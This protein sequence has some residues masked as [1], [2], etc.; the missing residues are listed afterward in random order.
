MNGINRAQRN[1]LTRLLALSLALWLTRYI[2]VIYLRIFLL[3]KI[4]LQSVH[5]DWLALG[6]WLLEQRLMTES[7]SLISTIQLFTDPSKVIS[8]FEKLLLMLLL[9]LLNWSMVREE[10]VGLLSDLRS[11][12]FEK[13]GHD[14]LSPRFEE[15]LEVFYHCL[16]TRLT[17]N[18]DSKDIFLNL[19]YRCLSN[20][21]CVI[22]AEHNFALLFK[23]GELLQE[24]AD[25]H[26][27]SMRRLLV[28][29]PLA[30]L[31]LLVLKALIR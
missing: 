29:V 21:S 4:L 10:C 3:L 31:R 28:H 17:L 15:H 13:E 16:T 27:L 30:W 25:V 18:S 7:L 5:S 6:L 11:E 23:L 14:L 1:L 2:R 12:H 8:S 26:D 24:L 20:K 9:H 19:G 22:L